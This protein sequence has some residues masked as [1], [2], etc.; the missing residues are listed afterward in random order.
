MSEQQQTTTDTG[1]QAPWY[2]G[3]QN[4]DLKGWIA[5]KGFS[6]PAQAAESAWNLEKLLGHDKAG[7]TIVMPKDEKDVD[8]WKAL[9]AK[10]GVPADATGY[11]IPESLKADPLIGSLAS[12]ALEA[13]IPVR[14]FDTLL[15]KMAPI[16]IEAEAKAEREAQAASAAELE[17]LKGE[18]GGEFEKNSEFARR[19]LRQSGLTDEQMAGIEK[20][21]GTTAMLKTFHSWG[22]KTAESNF[23]DTDRSGVGGKLVAQRQMN[24]LRARRVAGQVGDAEFYAEMDRLGKMMEAA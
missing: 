15:N 23:V 9:N 13:G 7:R 8:G 16:A 20:A 1:T 18:W 19:F 21:I 3:V 24:E 12:V 11:Q 4:A 22:A 14:A 5:S 17:K 10:L 2:D 6:D